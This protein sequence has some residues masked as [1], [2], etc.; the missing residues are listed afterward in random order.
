MS[1]SHSES[2]LRS[3]VAHAARTCFRISLYISHPFGELYASN[4]A[5]DHTNLY[6]QR[7]PEI[8]PARPPMQNPAWQ[9]ALGHGTTPSVG[10]AVVPQLT[11]DLPQARADPLCARLG[12]L[13]ICASPR[14][15][16]PYHPARA[17]RGPRNSPSPLCADTVTYPRTSSSS[18]TPTDAPRCLL[19]HPI[20]SSWVPAL[21]HRVCGLAATHHPVSPPGKRIRL[22]MSNSLPCRRVVPPVD[23]SPNSAGPQLLPTSLR[24][25][26]PRTVSGSSSLSSR[27]FTLVV[28]PSTAPLVL[29]RIARHALTALP[30]DLRV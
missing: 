23:S 14:A 30:L 7:D 3:Q 13:S 18:L 2:Q 17:P 16:A 26:R 19:V 6:V 29:R 8:R 25:A 9:E 22:T 1:W 5:C 12:S 10:A 20:H 11:P 28:A 4:P 15:P 24:L 21:S 27:P